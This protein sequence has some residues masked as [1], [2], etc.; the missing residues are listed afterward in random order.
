MF[1]C[2]EAEETFRKALESLEDSKLSSDQKTKVKKDIKNSMAANKANQSMEK[3]FNKI[4]N[5]AVPDEFK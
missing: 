2:K 5:G 4:L 1:R 3:N